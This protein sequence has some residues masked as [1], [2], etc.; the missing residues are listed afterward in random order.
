MKNN[1]DVLN[2]KL[3]E[4]S[5]SNR[6]NKSVRENNKTFIQKIK[7]INTM[8]FN[9][10]IEI[11]NHYENAS[12]N[13][14]K[15]K[16]ALNK[17]RLSIQQKKR[18][19]INSNNNTLNK[20]LNNL[21]NNL[22]YNSIEDFNYLNNKMNYTPFT[23]INSE[24]KVFDIKAP[25]SINTNKNK[26]S[27]YLNIYSKN[28]NIFNNNI[29]NTNISLYKNKS[30][31]NNSIPN[32]INNKKYI[33]YN[34]YIL[35]TNN[36]F[37]QS[38]IKS[39]ESKV[40]IKKAKIKNFESKFLKSY[41]KSKQNLDNL[42][43]KLIMPKITQS[44]LDSK[45]YQI[46]ENLEDN[47]V[48]KKN[49]KY[50]ITQQIMLKELRN[51][52]NLNNVNNFIMILKQHILIE[53]EFNDLISYKNQFEYKLISKIKNLINLYNAFFTQLDYITFEINI[54]LNKDN[55]SLLQKVLKLLIYYHTFIFIY[56]V[57]ND[58]QTILIKIKSNF[59]SIFKK[60]SFCI[61][62]IFTKYIYKELLNSKYKDLSFVT[63]LNTLFN[64][65]NDYVIKAT[66]SNSEIYTLIFKYFN[67]CLDLFIKALNNEKNFM[68]EI[69]ISLKDL[70]LNLNIKDLIHHIDICLNTFLYSILDKN[71]QKAKL[72]KEKNNSTHER[73]S[74][75]LVPYL[76]PLSIDNKFN[77]KFKYTIVLDIDETLGHFIQ[78]EVKIDY[79]SNYGYFIE[80]NNK[81]IID[82]K[83]KDKMRTGI[84]LIRPYA[85][86]FLEK[87]NN[88]FFEIVVFSAGTKEY[89]DK[90]LDILDINNNIIK[91]RLYRT[92]LSLR[93][94]N[95][96]V[97]DLS[98]LGRDLSK[99]IMIDNFSE[100]Y[101][102]QQ[103]NGLPIDSWTGN[104]NDTS[105]RDLIPIMNYIV[106]NN[107]D[108]VRDIVKKVKAQLNSF[109]KRYFNY[110]KINLKF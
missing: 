16:I 45:K 15:T 90:V 73:K 50:F 83:N 70:L 22:I 82:A 47:K 107:V 21:K 108:D 61:Y 100:N 104:A 76:P 39:L 43:F 28:N 84:F 33:S 78:N 59:F 93:N 18:N 57:L 99:V 89:C 95:N 34:E 56:I 68:E 77:Q 81:S 102:L 46:F 103:D 6:N 25:N 3:P 23:K 67:S 86:Y 65:N 110:E 101:K 42:K 17:D 69:S 80:K 85:K 40:T 8:R 11:T 74:L 66:L 54:F 9:R 10:N 4:I 38:N 55:N 36:N 79:F 51:I 97:K 32:I 106:E 5:R 105:L 26:N 31:R 37:S 14:N 64:N 63:N 52:E 19:T 60:I 44:S 2:L 94:I 12:R 41:G 20:R 30:N 29:K 48:S 58:I 27:F 109:S 88:L 62:N 49:D 7:G 96:D 13:N 1:L 98:L 75:N 35:K 24:L 92:H 71:I 72:N 87:I 91:Y 53:N